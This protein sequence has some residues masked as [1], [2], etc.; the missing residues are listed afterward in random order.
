M[1]DLIWKNSTNPIKVFIYKF[2][3]ICFLWKFISKVSQGQGHSQV[4]KSFAPVYDV[5]QENQQVQHYGTV[6]PVSVDNYHLPQPVVDQK[7]YEGQT[8]TKVS[9]DIQWSVVI[10]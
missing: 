6:S 8:A 2:W 9:F 10:N 4:Q 7:Q 5:V 1:Q 3:T